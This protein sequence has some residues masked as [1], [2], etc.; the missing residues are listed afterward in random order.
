MMNYN[1]VTDDAPEGMSALEIASAGQRLGAFLVD[2]AIS[3]LVGIVG[4]V[5]GSAMGGDG[6]VVN[7]VLSISYWIVVL[8][9]VATRGQSPGKIAIG[10]KIVKTDGRPIGFG[11]TLLREVIGKIISSIIILLGYIWILFDGQRQ[12]WHDKIAST[13]VVKV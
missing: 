13:Y 8:V 6:S 4:L 12:G 10:I 11:T 1:V 5:I 9:M 7:F 3:V 2:F